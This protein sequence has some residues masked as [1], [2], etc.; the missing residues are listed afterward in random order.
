M[1][2]LLVSILMPTRGRVDLARRSTESLLNNCAD[3]SHV[4]IVVA[5]DNDDTDSAQFF[6]SPRWND[7]ITSHGAHSQ[8]IRCEPWGYQGLHRYYTTMARQA[9]GKWFMI[10]NDD[11]V[12]QSQYWDKQVEQNQDWV[13]LLHMYTANFKPS[14]TLFPLI[15]RLWLDLFGEISLHQLNDSW[16]QDVCHQAEAVK[17]IP[18]SVFHDRYDV[19]GNNL[20]E[21]Y[22]RRR[23]DKKIYNH[24][25][26]QAIRHEWAQRLKTYRQQTHACDAKPVLT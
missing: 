24:E 7:L 3:A 26:M 8:V 9:K 1:S 25:S 6:T 14:L 16:I 22:A 13:G 21:T 18:V 19:T 23:Y 12:M 17:S 20:D 4:E 10:W 2:S 5:Y 11:A 15:P